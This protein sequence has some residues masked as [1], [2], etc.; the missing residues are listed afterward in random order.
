MAALNVKGPKRYANI[1]VEI[2]YMVELPDELGH[3]ETGAEYPF[4]VFEALGA[5]DQNNWCHPSPYCK[6][7][8]VREE[9]A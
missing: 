4:S 6:V 7:V 1:R 8:N 2:E 5:V 9:V 3:I